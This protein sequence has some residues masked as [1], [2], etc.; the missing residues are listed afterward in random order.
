MGTITEHETF[1]GL[2]RH[3]QLDGRNLHNKEK[4]KITWPD[5]TTEEITILVKFRR[6]GIEQSHEA[7]YVSRYHGR[8]A[9]SRLLGLTAERV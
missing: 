3:D 2:V 8:D 9:W 6:C 4:L 7:Y 1:S 5:G